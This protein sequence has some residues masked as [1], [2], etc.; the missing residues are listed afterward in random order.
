MRPVNLLPEEQRGRGVP[1]GDPLISYGIVGALGLLLLMVFFTILQSNKAATLADET[2]DLRAQAAKYQ[3]K[4]APVTK[5]SDFG[6]EVDKRKLL[7]GGLAESRFPWHTALFN[8]SQTVPEEVTIDSITGNATAAADAAA[9]PAPGATATSE[10]PGVVVTLTGC[11]RDWV[12]YAKFAARLKTM[13]GVLEVKMQ[14]GGRQDTEEGGAAAGPA[15]GVGDT[16]RHS[17][18]GPRPLTFGVLVKYRQIPID[19][20]GLPKISSAG[21]SSATGAAPAPTA[22]T[23]AAPATATSTGAG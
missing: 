7:I 4:A 11:A 23:G 20:I 10:K 18:C 5:Y 22:G 14:N 13:P 3:T 19:L 16:A 2:T 21:A 9:A 17:N 8:I 1:T 12:P 15:T 6:D